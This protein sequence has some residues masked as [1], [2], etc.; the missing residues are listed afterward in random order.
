L[1]SVIFGR[2]THLGLVNVLCSRA[3]VDLYQI[4][5]RS[6]EKNRQ[7]PRLKDAGIQIVA[8]DTIDLLFRDD[9]EKS[10]K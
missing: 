7:R 10:E 1:I 5:L 4:L 6:L 3:T 9:S 8:N 2:H